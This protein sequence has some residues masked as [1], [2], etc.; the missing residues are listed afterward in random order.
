MTNLSKEDR[1]NQISRVKEAI[2]A[3]QLLR[4]LGFD[5]SRNTADEVRAPCKVHGG[6]NKT[7]FRMSKQTK[8]W[9]CF[10]H[11]CHENVGYDVISL[12]RHVL[13]L[14]F[15]DAMKY[16]ESISG[17]NIHDEAAYVEYKRQ[18]DKRVFM[19]RMQ[20]NKQVPSALVSEE[21]LKSFRKF[22][23]IYF[24]D[25]GFSSSL[26]DEFE[27]GGGY[28]DKYGF[29][30]DVI[31]IR[32]SEGVLRAYSCRDTTGKADYDYKYLLTKGFDKDKVLY[33]L[34]R[35]KQYM[36]EKRI[37]I[38]VEGFKAMWNCHRAGY[39]NTVACMG[40]RITT[41][42]QNLLYSNAFTI[43]LLLDGDDPGMLGTAKAVKDMRGKINI[44]PKFFPYSDKDPGDVSTE[45][46]KT[47][48]GG[49]N[50]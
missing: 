23:S 30:R 40:S 42:Q 41:G 11:G 37:L 28:V 38:I 47:I 16:L 10:S 22:R 18:K 33:N 43:I 27:V 44:V 50:G 21:Y 9:L 24:E 5:I 7:S 29:Q 45:E 14:S 39:K 35:A 3:D 6:D 17:V 19:D 31:P 20:D 25:K 49:S 34:Y 4:A 26:L 15:P 46:L 1:R 2:D 8:N 13:G 32:D 48:I 12:V 36:G